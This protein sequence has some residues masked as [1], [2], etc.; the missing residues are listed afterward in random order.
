MEE[1]KERKDTGGGKVKQDFGCI[2][3]I[4]D[5][6]CVV[7]QIFDSFRI[8]LIEANIDDIHIFVNILIYLPYESFEFKIIVI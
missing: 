3:M 5:Q 2:E 6:N 4:D 8:N 1:K 7:V